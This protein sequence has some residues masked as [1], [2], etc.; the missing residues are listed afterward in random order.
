MIPFC[1][2]IGVH[3]PKVVKKV[4]LRDYSEEQIKNLIKIIKECVR[5]NR[6]IISLED[7][8]V[9][10]IQFMQEYNINEKKRIDILFNLDYK[11]FCYGLKNLK[12]GVEQNNLYIF[13][14]QRELYNIE[15]KKELIDIY[16]KFNVIYNE[17]QEYRILVSLHKRNKPITYIFK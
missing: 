5:E 13:C 9:E 7:N 6:Y 16:L 12:D 14:V 1:Y 8:K 4:L 2:I 3:F 11:D 17:T 10:N 15:N